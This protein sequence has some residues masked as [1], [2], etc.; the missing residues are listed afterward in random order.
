M[1]T[2]HE[3]VDKGFATLQ[4]ELDEMRKEVEK[5]IEVVCKTAGSNEQFQARNK[6]PESDDIFDTTYNVDDA[7]DVK[8]E[9]P[10]EP[11]QCL[12]LTIYSPLPNIM[13]ATGNQSVVA[14]EKKAFN[15][16]YGVMRRKR[17]AFVSSPYVDPTRPKK[18]RT[19]N[20]NL[21]KFEP[22]KPVHSEVQSVYEAFKKNNKVSATLGNQWM[23]LRIFLRLLRVRPTGWTPG[24]LRLIW[25]YYGGASFRI[26][27]FFRK[28][29]T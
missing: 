2:L 25:Q 7:T 26:R 8:K 27:Q 21:M 20:A 16:K 14:L 22:L 9:E 12:Q 23:R 3:K 17:S 28:I 1:T 19:R 24:T 5:L 4:T 15:V 10:K 6:V 18:Q 29:T 11:D 13:S